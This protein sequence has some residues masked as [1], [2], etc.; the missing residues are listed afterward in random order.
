MS[1]E[2]FVPGEKAMLKGEGRDTM[3]LIAA[4]FLIVGLIAMVL[5]M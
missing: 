5:L 3:V 1:N 2:L 4:A